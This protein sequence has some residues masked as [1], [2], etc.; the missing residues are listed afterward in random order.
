MYIIVMDVR[1]IMVQWKKNQNLIYVLI[2]KRKNMMEDNNKGPNLPKL[3]K[4]KAWKTRRCKYCGND[5]LVN[6]GM[7]NWKNLFR[8]PTFDEWVMLFIVLMTIAS[9]YAYRMD[10]Q[11]INE[12]YER[13]D[14]CLNVLLSEEKVSEAVEYEKD[15]E[16][17]IDL[18]GFDEFENPDGR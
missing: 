4:K 13:G 16:A 9:S 18:P 8:K 6:T 17:L 11:N 5:A 14:H 3:D 1:G 2:V 10:I 7:H 15:M 12:Y